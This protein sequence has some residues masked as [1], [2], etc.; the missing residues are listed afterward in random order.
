MGGRTGRDAPTLE[1]VAALAG[2]S[3]ATAGR[4]LAGSPRVSEH[5]RDVVLAAAQEL[6]YV[7]NRAARS[8]MTRRS[9]SIA[10][11]VA[12]QEER[13]FAD[14]F[15]SL[16]LRGV[17]A[18]VAAHDVQ[19]VFAVLSTA[20]ERERFERFARGGHVD[21]VAFV[22]LRGADPLPARLQDAGVPV[23]LQGRPFGTERDAPAVVGYVDA[24]NHGGSRAATRLLADGGRTRIGTVTGPLDWRPPSTGSR[25]PAPS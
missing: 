14:P 23:M 1:S 12:E 21:G 13:F 20:A 22:S 11:V 25:A 9:D 8:L 19:I 4:V 10:F 17:H 24:D 7:T 5:A 2:V 16:V 3:R 15:F 6:S 18:A